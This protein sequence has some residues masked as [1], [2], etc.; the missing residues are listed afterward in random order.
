MVGTDEAIE[1][2][3]LMKVQGDGELKSIQ[4]A[5]LPTEPVASNEVLGSVVVRVQESNDP[6]P[7][8][9]DIAG[10][11]SPQPSERGGVERSGA[12]F[13]REHRNRLDEGQSGDDQF[14]PRLVD[15]PVDRRGA[16]LRMVVLDEGTRVEEGAGHVRN[17]PPV[18]PR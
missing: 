15:E 17:D 8:A 7:F 13:G 4:G 3:L 1:R 16:G 10:E 14:G 2:C 9:G 12:D 6:I 5:Y 18:L 11:A